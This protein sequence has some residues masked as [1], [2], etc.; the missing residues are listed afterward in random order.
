MPADFHSHPYA[1]PPCLEIAV[2]LL[3]FLTVLE[4]TLLELPSVRIHKRNLLKARMVIRSYNDHCSAPF[5][6]ALV[7]WHHQSLI[8]R[9]SRH[10]YAINYTQY[11]KAPTFAVGWDCSDYQTRNEERVCESGKVYR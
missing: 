7:A 5:S 9:G 10:C 8:G 1:C 2:K 6:R 3:C 4:S 11:K